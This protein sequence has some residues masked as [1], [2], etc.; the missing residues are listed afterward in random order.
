MDYRRILQESYRKKQSVNSRYSIRAFARDLSVSS[1]FLSDVLNGRKTLSFN[2]AKKLSERLALNSIEKDVFLS[3]VRLAAIRSPQELLAATDEHDR[4]V[5]D[6][7]SYRFLSKDEFASISHWHFFAVMALMS[8]SNFDCTKQNISKKLGLTEG[9]LNFILETLVKRNLIEFALEDQ[10]YQLVINSTET[11]SE[12]GSKDIQQFHSEAV[13]HALKALTDSI[14]DREFMSMI[15]A[16]DS[17]KLSEAKKDLQ[18]FARTFR[19]KYSRQ[20]HKDSVFQLGVQFTRI[21]KKEL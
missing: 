16:F 12:T 5:E 19:A 21:D 4:L 18:N 17:T 2:M 9:V 10:V 7:A 15:L 13:R 11:Q 6:Y 20:S 8:T 3:S 1:S 14:D